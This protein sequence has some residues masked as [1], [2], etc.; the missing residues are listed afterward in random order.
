VNRIGVHRKGARL[1]AVGL[2]V[3]IVGMVFAASRNAALA[4]PKPPMPIVTV[5]DAGPWRLSVVTGESSKGAGVTFNVQDPAALAAYAAAVGQIGPSVFDGQSEVLVL[6][7]FR[8]PLSI[9]RFTD[10]MRAS[11]VS[12][13]SY[14][15][16]TFESD[17]RRGTVGG[18]PEPDGTILSSQH[19]SS[20][21]QR[22][23]I[24]SGLATITVAGVI[25]AEV[26]L[27]REGYDSL[28]RNGTDVFLVDVM[29]GVAAR[30]L[31]KAGEHHVP[32]DEITLQPI[33]WFMEDFGMTGP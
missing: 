28:A 19:L 2:V 33:Y 20:I 18:A 23:Q 5:K 1:V 14:R 25:D 30:E 27:N 26:V 12:V 29:R 4:D 6:V 21:V 15:I 7:T 31:A 22:E 16:R 17:G 32:M 11:A 9:E 8:Y 3:I 10:L 24:K 13:K